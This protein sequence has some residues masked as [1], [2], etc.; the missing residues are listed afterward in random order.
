VVDRQLQLRDR[1]TINRSP[2]FADEAERPALFA[3][4]AAGGVV[5]AGPRIISDPRRVDLRPA[6]LTV[7]SSAD[8]HFA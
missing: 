4:A 2:E 8:R 7:T 3:T 1:Q 6:T 5:F